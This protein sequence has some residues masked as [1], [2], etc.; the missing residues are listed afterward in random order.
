[1]VTQQIDLRDLS[2]AVLVERSKA[3][4]QEAF[5]EI[6]ERYQSL[7][8]SVAY[9]RCGDLALSEDRA[10][11]A[12]LLAWNKLSELRDVGQFKAWLCTI[13]LN[14]TGR[15]VERQQRSVMRRASPL[16]HANEL[17]AG[18]LSPTDRVVLDEEQALVWSAIEEV[19]ETY[20]EPLI[21]FYR[22][23]QSVARVADALDLSHDAVKQRL[24]R[25]RKMLQQNLA[26]TVE[27]TL[28]KSKPCKKFTASVLGGV[29]MLM[30]NQATAASVT[31]AATT[32]VAKTATGSVAKTTAAAGIGAGL[33][34]T[35]LSLLGTLPV[36]RWMQKESDAS[37]EQLSEEEE[38]VLDQMSFRKPHVRVI[39][40]I[41]FFGGLYLTAWLVSD[42]QSKWIGYCALVIVLV[43][44]RLPWT[45]ADYRLAKRMHQ[46]RV[47]AGTYS[48]PPPLIESND[49]LVVIR[50]MISSIVLSGLM[51]TVWPVMLAVWAENWAVVSILLIASTG[52]SLIAALIAIRFPKYSLHCRG[53]SYPAVALLG[54]AV[55]SW[56]RLGWATGLAG[57]GWNF[58]AMTGIGMTMGVLSMINARKMQVDGRCGSTPLAGDP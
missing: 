37:I 20:R 44:A 15:D 29:S 18:G 58:M 7:L 56:F 41:L 23:G 51:I 33:G 26:S 4:D 13:V 57:F 46:K 53:L 47:D 48:P 9:S 21:L 2:D 25:G 50:K 39:H 11:E 6:V 30:T 5:G 45:I 35:F 42:M 40:L 52:I 3:R 16:E 43:I 14:L 38:Q 19:P 22:E 49:R 12:F 27:T 55:V 32:T 31:T 1:M 8:C 10:Q 28:A 24:S 36:L 34:L 17:E 54:I